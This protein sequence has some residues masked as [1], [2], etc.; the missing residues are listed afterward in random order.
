MSNQTADVINLEP[1]DADAEPKQSFVQKTKTFVKT[2]KKA[3]IAVVALGGL[4]GFSALTG[5][6]TA[7]V[8]VQSPLEFEVD[9]EQSEDESA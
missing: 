2:H 5:R 3:T 6:K 8:T 4:V 1:I 7:T 9:D